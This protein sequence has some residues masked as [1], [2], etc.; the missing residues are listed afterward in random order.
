MPCAGLYPAFHSLRSY[1]H[2]ARAKS[3]AALVQRSRSPSYLGP[4]SRLA[5]DLGPLHAAAASANS[6][7]DC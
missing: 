3:S 1:R 4:V 2:N 6:S 5:L 7:P